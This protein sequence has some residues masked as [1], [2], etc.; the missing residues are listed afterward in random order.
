MTD[1]KGSATSGPK[2][3]KIGRSPAY[4]SIPLSAALEKARAQYEMEGRYPAPLQSAFRA[5]GY[6]DKSSGG[7]DVRAS[8]RYFGLITIEGDGD[9]AKVQLTDDALRV[10]LD[11]RE[12]QTEKKAIIRRLALTPAAHKKLWT[13]YPEGIKST[14]TARHYLHFEEGFN[15][16]AAEA[17]IAEFQ[18]T[19]D[20][21]GLYQP[22]T[23]TVIQDAP[24][25]GDDA[26]DDGVGGDD[27]S[28]TRRDPPPAPK[29][30][31][32]VMDGERVAFTEESQPGQYL[33]LIASGEFDDMMLEALEDFVKRQ[34][35]RLAASQQ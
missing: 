11:D 35:K 19:A 28:G 6:S 31:V 12:D 5:W 2:R 13:K 4:P 3:L 34:R 24:A 32:S 33:K 16:S 30:R 1:T 7:R 26:A 17:L 27:E 22:D 21:A 14:A 10:I 23:M 9:L 15:P 8:L 20:F 18:A 29:G 25:G